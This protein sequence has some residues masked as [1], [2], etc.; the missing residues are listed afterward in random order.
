MDLNLENNIYKEILDNLTYE[1]FVTDSEGEIIYCNEAF[2]KNY[3]YNVSDIIGKQFSV[4]APIIKKG[5]QIIPIVLEEKKE[6]SLFQETV[7]GKKLFLT[8]KPVFNDENKLKMVV[9]NA[10]EVLNLSSKK[11]CL[12]NTDTENLKYQIDKY[13][14]QITN[15]SNIEEFKN[16]NKIAGFDV[17]VL[18]LGESGTG[19]STCAKFIHNISKRKDGPFFTVN[20]TTIPENLIES[21]LFGYVKGAFT[22][23][24]KEGKKGLVELANNGTL[25]LDEIGEL[26]LSSQSKLLELIENRT[27]IPVGGS[28]KRTTNIRIIAA[29]NKDIAEMVRKGKFREDLYYRINV[30]EFKI[31]PLRERK[32][33]IPILAQVFV[34]RINKKYN[35]NKI[36]SDSVLVQLKK[37]SWPGN[38]RQLEHVL[39]QIL[40]STEDDFITIKNL[41]KKIDYTKD[42]YL[43]KNIKFPTLKEHIE[44][45]EIELII[46]AYHKYGSSYKVAEALDISQSQAIRKIRKYISK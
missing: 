37:Y 24:V 39:E 35:L 3:C 33:A 30:I 10:R 2:S 26:P 13:G 44:N 14:E 29:T 20:C 34:D 23:A 41:E 45:S 21:E 42:G 4:I 19:K 43:D 25:F 32:E 31:P 15:F 38:L 16:L 1:V 9:E 40:L 46:A 36:I 12:V 8:A 28:E 5:S 11:E 6:I 18:L 7:Y 22:G 27:Y 17:T